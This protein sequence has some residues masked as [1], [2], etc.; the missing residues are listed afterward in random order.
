M[1]KFFKR[2]LD[3]DDVEEDVEESTERKVHSKQK[4]LETSIKEGV[5]ADFSAGIGTNYI[6]PFAL[7]LNASPFQIGIL[8]SLSGLASPFAQLKG[9]RMMLR[10]S[11][12]HLVLNFV[13]LQAFIWLPIS[14]LGI[15]L[16]KG[17]FQEY[18]VYMLIVFYTIYAI[19]MGLATPSWFSWMGDLVP[20]EDRGKY[21]SIRNRAAGVAA[22]VAVLLS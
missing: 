12:K 16:W 2:F 10:H 14:L 15:L 3:I 9:S 6:T 17:F 19:F 7:A 4:A 5:A 11:R 8:S 1:V 13:L 21:F 20:P 18:L 22:I